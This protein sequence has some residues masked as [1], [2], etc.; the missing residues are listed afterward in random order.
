MAT[1]NS[2]YGQRR[3]D[4]SKVAILDLAILYLDKFVIVFID[5][6]LIYSRSK[7]EY[8]EHL[9]LI[10]DLASYERVNEKEESSF[11][12]LKQKLCNAPILSLLKGTENFVVY[13]DASHKGLGAVLM[14]KEKV[15]AYAFRQLKTHEKNYTTHDLELGD[16]VFALKIWRH[17]LYGT[18][19]DKMYHDLKKLYWW[20]NM[21]AAIAIYV[22]K[23]LTCSKVRA[24]YQKPSGLLV[25][26]KIP[27]WKWENITMDFITKLPKTLSDYGTIWVIV[28]RPTKSTRFL[29]IKEID[30]MEKLR[31]L[32]KFEAECKLLATNR[33]VVR[34]SDLMITKLHMHK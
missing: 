6:I 2:W 28:D 24:E 16:I 27:Q 23:S 3:N 9:K 17:Y 18:K 5:D 20:P 12:L 11:Q 7:E 31:R 26:P 19:S 21:K 33:K 22:S 14:Q 29:L 34:I 15:I 10:Q 8:E 4:N 1:I 30:K 13:C 32:Y 25:Q